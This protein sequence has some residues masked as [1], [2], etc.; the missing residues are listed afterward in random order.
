[1]FKLFPIFTLLCLFLVSCS[2]NPN[3]ARE[4]TKGTHQAPS[5]TAPVS[6]PTIA[7]PSVSI[8]P[9]PKSESLAQLKRNLWSDTM[10][11]NKTMN[12]FQ[13]NYGSGNIGI[14][15][16]NQLWNLKWEST[17]SS[18]L[19]LVIKSINDAYSLSS[20]GKVNSELTPSLN[21][22]ELV[23]RVIELLQSASLHIDSHL[24]YSLRVQ[25]DQSKWIMTDTKQ[26][27]NKITT[28]DRKASDIQLIQYY[29]KYRQRLNEIKNEITRIDMYY[30]EFEEDYFNNF[31]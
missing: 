23:V 25:T 30:Q 24:A 13:Y 17:K 12:D 1:M 4:A 18:D 6:S 26:L 7:G 16:S 28:E 11:L 8:N 22:E 10:G 31:V 19:T 5:I 29:D 15:V 21:D 9:T 3:L 14:S 20:T 2:Q 27:G